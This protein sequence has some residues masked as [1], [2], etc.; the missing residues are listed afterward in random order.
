MVFE[1]FDWHEDFNAYYLA[2]LIKVIEMHLLVKSL[3]VFSYQ[4]LHFSSFECYVKPSPLNL[5]GVTIF[6][7]RVLLLYVENTYIFSN[8][9]RMITKKNFLLVHFMLGKIP[10]VKTL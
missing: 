7:L 3:L 4:I 1:I 10:T 8:T 2:L 9:W 5:R 6:F